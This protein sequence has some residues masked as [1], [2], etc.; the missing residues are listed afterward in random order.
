MLCGHEEVVQRHKITV[1]NVFHGWK[2]C[3]GDKTFSAKVI[4][5]SNE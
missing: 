5:M 1:Q 2:S 3:Q 4:D